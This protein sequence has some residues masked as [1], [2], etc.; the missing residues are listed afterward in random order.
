M[1][2]T[3]QTTKLLI[4]HYAII[5]GVLVF[6]LVV[7]Y[8]SKDLKLHFENDGMF[9]YLGPIAVF[10]AVALHGRIFAN[11]IIHIDSKASASSKFALYQ[12][13]HIT[14]HA[15]LEA[16]AL[17]NIVGALL[18][19]NA[20]FLLLAAALVLVMLSYKPTKQKIIQLLGLTAAE[21]E[22]LF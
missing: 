21:I 1:Q 9:L 3:K 12:S 16:A 18:T 5:L 17:V 10:L 22:E 7:F 15:L 6:G 8:T 4:I 2:K 14:R 20:L 19:D 13:A 11:M